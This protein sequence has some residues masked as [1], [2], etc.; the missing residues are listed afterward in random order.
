MNKL[1][2]LLLLMTNFSY[3]KDLSIERIFSSP[4]LAGTVMRSVKFSPSGNRVTFLQGKAENK[5]QFDLWEY[6]I[7]SG[8]K[9]LL[10][11]SKVL[12][13]NGEQLSAEEK[14]RRERQRTASYSGIVEY[15]WAQ[16]GKKILFPLSGNLYVYNLETNT[17][18][19]IT[20]SK[21]FDTDARFSPIGNYVSFIRKQNIYIVNLVKNKTIQLTFDGKDVIKNGMAEFVAQEEMDRDTGYWWS[22]NDENI[23]YVQVDES[24]VAITKRY[25][26]NAETIE[27][28]EQR[29]PYTGDAN[30]KVK[31]GIMNLKKK[32]TKWIDLGENQDIYLTRVQWLPNAKKLSYQVMSRNQQQLNLYVANLKGKNK[33]ILQENSKTW[34]NLHNDLYYMKD[35]T[36]IWASERDGFKHLYHYKNNGQ[37]IKQLTQGHWIVD[38]IEGIDE[39]KA[40]LYFSASKQSPTEKHLY[41]LNLKNSKITQVS[42][43]P[44]WHEIDMDDNA[45]FYIDNWSST[46]Q[47][48]N[49]SL[50]DVTGKEITLLNDN[51]ID[52]NHP[53]YPYLSSHQAT[54]FGTLSSSD[55]QRLHYRI[56]KP[57]DFDSSKKYPVFVYT[58]GGPHAQVVTNS[59]GKSIDQYMAQ[60]GFIVFSLDNRG[61]ARRGVKFESPIY[62][63]MGTPEIADQLVG[64]DYLK[65][66]AY[67]D[68]EKI[69]LF[70]WSYGGFMTLKAVTKSDVF[71]LGVSV[72]PVADF[73]L[74]DTFY[75]ER[76]MSTPQL[77]E[78]GYKSTAVFDDVINI[79]AKLLVIHGMADDNVLF[80]NS[81]KLFKALQDAGILY[82]SVIYPGAKHG[83]SGEK[84]QKHV[85]KTISQYFI[86]HLKVGNQQEK[87]R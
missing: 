20:K 34:L 49:T 69:G 66:L 6:N 43:H 39:T 27:I 36:F 19:Q 5:D 68:A 40:L 8:K 7:Q 31:L 56:I 47:P 46:M 65:S 10:V 58:Y 48:A 60:Q 16:D 82:D 53:Y 18:Q 26:I 22:S 78:Q 44:G 57:K 32:K 25:E 77:N 80:T 9:Q 74:Y 62:K 45:Q 67:V 70:G 3:T 21:D 71:A 85:W 59:W 24:P 12:L 63:Q 15:S 33:Q 83:I 54:E 35:K 11:D 73:E 37:L 64:V 1:L 76:Y 75:T 50:Y 81:T 42:K 51:R 17:V 87:K 23:A 55:G 41:V 29:Y 84:S 72:A 2:I 38:A 13:P 30:V 4:S 28:V 14:A 79:K 61:S 86:K 52:K